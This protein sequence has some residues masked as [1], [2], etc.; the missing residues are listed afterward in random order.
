MRA[1]A[2]S[3]LVLAACGAST[4]AP[5]AAVPSAPASAV[6]PVQPSPTLA[7]GMARLAFMRGVWAGPASG[8]TPTGERYSVTQT[9]RMGP[10]LGGDVIVIEGRG[11]QADG[12]TGLNALGVVSW[13]PRTDRYE[14]RSY[15]QGH[16]GTFEMRL[17]ADGYTWEVPAGPGAVMRFTATVTGDRWR[18]IG[19]YVAGD[20]PPRQMFEMNLRRVGETDWPLGTPIAPSVTNPG[21]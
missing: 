13:D 7:K 6:V 2:V 14:I 4:S 10:L 12:T 1:A 17:T 8:V 5:V 15:A 9:E 11:Y 19:E 20:K 16:A 21:T 18:E 3:I